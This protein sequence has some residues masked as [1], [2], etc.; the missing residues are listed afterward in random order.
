PSPPVAKSPPTPPPANTAAVEVGTLPPEPVIRTSQEV[1]P[2]KA[3]PTNQQ[4]VAAAA[5]PAPAPA[6]SADDKK[7]DKPGF[8][9]RV[10]PLN[11]FRREPKAAPGSTPLPSSKKTATTGSP[12]P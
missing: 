9:S 5:P 6:P 10:N 4:P 7:S 11:L 1:L 8:F 3:A 12:A 2:P